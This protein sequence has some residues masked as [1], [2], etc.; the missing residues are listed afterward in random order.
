MAKTTT[1]T[2]D[3]QE[4]LYLSKL[5]RDL[6][7]PPLKIATATYFITRGKLDSAELCLDMAIKKIISV[8]DSDD[9]QLSWLIKAIVEKAFVAQKRKDFVR[10][11]LYLDLASELLKRGKGRQA[12]DVGLVWTAK[13][14][15]ALAQHD[16]RRAK[17]AFS[18]AV[19]TLGP[20]TPDLAAHAKL[21]GGIAA[22]RD[23]DFEK[24]LAMYRAASESD[25][26][27][28]EVQARLGV[29]NALTALDRSDDAIA[30]CKSLESDLLRLDLR[31]VIRKRVHAALR[32]KAASNYLRQGKIAKAIKIYHKVWNKAAIVDRAKIFA[33]LAV[34]EFSRGQPDRAR[35]HE[36]ETQ[37]LIADLKHDIPEVLLSLSQL[38]L[39]RGHV[40]IAHQQLFDA[41]VELPK[42]S[43]YRQILLPYTIIDI[44][45]GRIKGE[46][47]RAKEKAQELQEFLSRT[48]PISSIHATI[49]CILGSLYQLDGNLD[50]AY[51]FYDQ[52]LSIG[53]QV[54]IPGSIL[55]AYSRL[56]QVALE[57]YEMDRALQYFKRAHKIADTVGQVLSAH[58]LKISELVAEMRLRGEPDEHDAI[59]LSELL[60]EGYRLESALLDFQAVLNLAVLWS[61]LGDLDRAIDYFKE[62]AATAQQEGLTLAALIAKG[63]LAIAL[64]NRGDKAQ[65]EK[66][67][68]DVLSKMENL[69]IEIPAK[70]EFEERYRDL[71]GFLF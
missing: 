63:L 57:R 71:T 69:G 35:F 60:E 56:G 8:T 70:D 65:A 1:K 12:L 53:K 2:G 34:L 64:D 31:Q 19:R 52:S 45:I 6:S 46:L 16:Y 49:L 67:L 13:G 5:S 55:Q 7:G 10:A 11:G 4:A 27:S 58:S 20:D 14:T 26:P 43:Q 29:I 39:M 30:A 33:T 36:K 15:L 50:Q 44:N 22:Y 40:D 9:F 59:V 61:Q 24:S 68:A 18:K 21:S 47:L 37:D 3:I 25:N 42:D 54:R 62:A 28:V 66:L 48:I 23:F 32:D 17:N 38:N 51:Q 41:M